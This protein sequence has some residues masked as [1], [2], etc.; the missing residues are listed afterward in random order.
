MYQAGQSGSCPSAVAPSYASMPRL[1]A[2]EGI[3]VYS[4]YLAGVVTARPL[5]DGAS[6]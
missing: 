4:V 5:T 3:R 2:L 6:P 1:E